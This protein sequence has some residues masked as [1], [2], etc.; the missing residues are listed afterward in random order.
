MRTKNT[1]RFLAAAAGL[2]AAAAPGA[3][4]LEVAP[5][6]FA[7]QITQGQT[8]LPDAVQVGNP[9]DG[10]LTYSVIAGSIPVGWL[11]AS[12]SDGSAAAGV[13]NTVV[14]SYDTAPLDPGI[15]AGQ[16]DVSA[17]GVGGRT[18]NIDLRINRRPGLAWDAAGKAWTNHIMA[19]DTLPATTLSIWNPSGEPAGASIPSPRSAISPSAEATRS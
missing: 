13:T 4:L 6:F 18:V 14:L 12:P 1:L 8:L 3:P 19:G 15:Y 7:K 5:T 2:A 11:S 16:V 17:L 10:T 9:G